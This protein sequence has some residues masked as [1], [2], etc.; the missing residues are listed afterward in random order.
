[1]KLS[2]IHDGVLLVCAA[3]FLFSWFLRAKQPN[4]PKT[5]KIISFDMNNKPDNLGIRTDFSTFDVAWNTMK[6][7]KVNYPYH[8]FALTTQYPGDEKPT[9]FKYLA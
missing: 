3:V 1:M 5:Y 6:Q 2:S 7:Y 4:K 8:G 9:I